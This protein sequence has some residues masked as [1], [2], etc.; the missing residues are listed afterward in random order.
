MNLYIKTSQKFYRQFAKAK[1]KFQEKVASPEFNYKGGK[2]YYCAQ[3]NLNMIFGR[4]N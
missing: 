4:I 2:F 1:L 3:A